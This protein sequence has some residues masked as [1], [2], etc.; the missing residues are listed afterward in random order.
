MDTNK[1]VCVVQPSELV[2]TNRFKLGC[3]V[4]QGIN[5]CIK[6]YRKGT[7]LICYSFCN[8]PFLT[9]SKLKSAFNKKF[10]LICGNEF[11]EGECDE[12]KKVFFKVIESEILAD[13]INRLEEE[14]SSLKT[15]L[16]KKK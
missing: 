1:I 8:D 15:Q 6:G 7:K 11:F 16:Y 5:R 9:E 13:K 3:S 12:I 4:K 2:G 14:N 10:R